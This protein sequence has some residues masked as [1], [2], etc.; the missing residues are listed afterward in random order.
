MPVIIFSHGFR[1]RATQSRFLMEALAAHGY[2]VFAPSHRDARDQR[3]GAVGPA[4][5]EERF[6]KPEAWSDKNYQDRAQDVRQ[7]LAAIQTDERF[8]DQANLRQLGLVGHSLGGYTVLGLGGAW[9]AWKLEGV[10]AVLALSPYSQPFV[11]H[12]TLGDLAA[13][14]MYQGGTLDFGI[15]PTLHKSQGAY[16][17]TPPPKYCVELAGAGHLAWSDLRPA[18]HEVIIAYSLAFLDHYVRGLPA[19]A[20]LT[21]ARPG[22]ASLRFASEL[23]TGDTGPHKGRRRSWRQRLQPRPGE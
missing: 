15:T 8:R 21:R 17:Q 5:P 19:A 9:P 3:G 11:A 20:V 23:G 2:L 14:V 10:K 1:S 22:V 16:D 7:L 6:R 18:A 13:P 12:H 4:K